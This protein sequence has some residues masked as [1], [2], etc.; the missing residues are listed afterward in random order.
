MRLRGDGVISADRY[1]PSFLPFI[2][3]IKIIEK[4]SFYLIKESFC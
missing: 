1:V 4:F 2:G 3:A